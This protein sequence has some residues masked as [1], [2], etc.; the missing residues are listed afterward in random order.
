MDEQADKN[1]TAVECQCCF[2][3]YHPEN[4]STSQLLLSSPLRLLLNLD[5]RTTASCPSSHPFCL[6]CALSNAKERL[7]NRLYTL[8]CLSDCG[9]EFT[10]FEARRFL[11]K[12]TLDLLHKIR[13][14]KE[15]DLAGLEGLEKCP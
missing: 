2:G 7:G 12:A 3:S 1:G 11:P 9:S 8:P 10:E 14:E 4:M 15:V 5:S 6:T 13:M